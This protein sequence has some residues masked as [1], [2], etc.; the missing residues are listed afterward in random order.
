MERNRNDANLEPQRYRE[1]VG[2]SWAIRRVLA[3]LGS[4]W[5]ASG[6]ISQHLGVISDASGGVRR[7]AEASRGMRRHLEAP[8]GL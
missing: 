8:G 1:H 3:A 6:I 5:E 4:I 7:L 2:A